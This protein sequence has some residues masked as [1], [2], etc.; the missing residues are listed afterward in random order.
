MGKVEFDVQKCSRNLAGVRQASGTAREFLGLPE[1]PTHVVF[2]FSGAGVRED[3]FLIWR[4]MEEA[5]N[6]LTQIQRLVTE[7]PKSNVATIDCGGCY[8]CL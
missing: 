8:S 6:T 3:V 7:L 4:E 2:L 1:P 5:C